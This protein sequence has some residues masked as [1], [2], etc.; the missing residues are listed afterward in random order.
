MHLSILLKENIFSIVKKQVPLPALNMR[1]NPNAWIEAIQN[2]ETQL[3]HQNLRIMNLDLMNSHL[4][5]AWIAYTKDLNTHKLQLSFGRFI[6]D[7][8]I[9]PRSQ[10]KEYN[11]FYLNAKMKQKK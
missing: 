9:N 3:E 5:K 1:K 6:Q 7:L 11:I 2:A 4:S 10:K 8:V